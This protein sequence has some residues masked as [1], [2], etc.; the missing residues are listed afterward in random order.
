MKK[1]IILSTA[2]LLIA[3]FSTKVMA[4]SN[5]SATENTSAGAWLMLQ[6]T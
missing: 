3:G 6:R 4:Q 5:T 2:V 1:L